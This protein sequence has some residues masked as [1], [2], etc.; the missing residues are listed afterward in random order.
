MRDLLTTVG[1]LVGA[2]SITVGAALVAPAAGFVTA[3][4]LLIVGCVLE[5][6]K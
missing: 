2:A 6:Q 1:E 3:G 5:A 4:I